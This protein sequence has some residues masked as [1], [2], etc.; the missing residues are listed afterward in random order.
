MDKP[1]KFK[2]DSEFQGYIYAKLESIDEK[3]NEACTQNK[4]Q[5]E[6]LNAVENRLTATEI[7]SGI[8]GTLGGLIGGFLGG[9]IK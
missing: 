3:L 9:L 4:E 5:G 1:R 6:R 2:N 8:F 7:K